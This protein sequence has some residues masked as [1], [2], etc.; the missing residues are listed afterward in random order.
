MGEGRVG[1]IWTASGV[2]RLDARR[3]ESISKAVGKLSGLLYYLP[4]EK[5]NN[6]NMLIEVVGVVGVVGVSS[7]QCLFFLLPL[8]TISPTGSWRPHK[9]SVIVRFPCVHFGFS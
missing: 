1:L 4:L 2:L 6:N 9:L 3:K 7:K 5:N 8:E